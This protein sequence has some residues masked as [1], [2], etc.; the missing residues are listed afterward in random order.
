MRGGPADPMFV[1]DLQRALQH[2]Y[3]PTELR[4]SRLVELLGV[5]EREDP[6]GCLRRVLTEA[7]QS[8]KPK[9]EVPPQANAWRVYHVLRQRYVESF[10][11]ADIAASLAVSPRQLRR[12]HALA[13]Q[14]LADYLWAGHNLAQRAPEPSPFSSPAGNPTE[15]GPE[16]MTQARELEWLKRSSPNEAV[17]VAAAIDSSLA[18]VAPLM[19]AERNEALSVAAYEA[20]WSSPPTLA[21]HTTETLSV[22]RQ[23]PAYQ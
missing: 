1:R 2:L 11:M 5:A 3:D 16:A 12:L 4:R 13:L 19:E 23:F 9:A 17:D 14:A 8:L 7:I 20:F 21:R 10:A 18:I 15:A 6:T 22:Y